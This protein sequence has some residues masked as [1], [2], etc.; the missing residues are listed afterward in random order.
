MTGFDR[1]VYAVTLTAAAAATAFLIAPVSYHRIVFRK[2][3]KPQ[4]VRTGSVLAAIGLVCLLVAMLG[5]VFLAV[6]I[7]LGVPL[8]AGVVSGLAGLY[9]FLWYVLP[10]LGRRR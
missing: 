5:A 9:V 10:F 3:R 4:L 1:R 6:D 8:A 7:V 2:G